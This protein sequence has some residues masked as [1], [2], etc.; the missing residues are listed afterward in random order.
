MFRLIFEFEILTEYESFALLYGPQ[1]G[2][3]RNLKSAYGE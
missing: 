1:C 2:V 3:P